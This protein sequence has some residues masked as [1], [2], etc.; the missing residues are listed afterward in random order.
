MKLSQL[1]L[2]TLALTLAAGFMQAEAQAQ[3]TTPA[4][5]PVSVLPPGSAAQEAE[6]PQLTANYRIV[7][8]TAAGDRSL[9]EIS[10]Q[11]CSSSFQI[12]GSLSAQ[13]EAQPDAPDLTLRGDLSEQADGTLKLGYALS[14]TALVP[15]SQVGKPG[16]ANLQTTYRSTRHGGSGMLLLK[17][18]Q[19]YELM[20]V[21]GVAYTLS[22]TPIETWPAAKPKAPAS[23]NRKDS[24][25]AV[26]EKPS[27]TERD[28]P[29]PEMRKQYE[30]LSDAAK[31]RLHNRMREL[32][33]Q[34][35]ELPAEER[36]AR[37][38]KLFDEVLAEDK[39][40]DK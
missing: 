17:P 29:D 38:R 35:R 16:T 11:T 24:A 27:Y 37:V 18:G 33:L 2:H 36:R 39:A 9:G 40:Q 25:D 7:I 21:S 15:S 30:S 12:S 31:E 32:F 34:I 20:Q 10:T 1:I 23:P 22:I 14:S 26:K 3:T 5:R 8:S 6:A 28:G 19:K 13:Q 4:L